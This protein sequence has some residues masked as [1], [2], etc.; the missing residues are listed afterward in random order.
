[1]IS[2]NLPTKNTFQISLVAFAISALVVNVVALFSTNSSLL[3]YV[4]EAFAFVYILLTPGLFLLPFLTHR[5]FHF[6]L[7]VTLS[8]ALSVLLL[9]VVGLVVNTLLPLF[10]DM[11]PLLPL[12]LLIAF[13]ILIFT[14]FILND[15]YKADFA[16][17]IPELNK[18]STALVVISFLLPIIACL[19]AISLNNGGSNFLS[20]LCLAIIFFLVPTLVIAEEWIDD[21]VP[22]MT[23]YF[24]ALTLLLMNSM[25]GWFV[26]G[27][28]IL[29][30]YHV[31]TLAND[32]HLW[33]IAIFR[34]P[35][36]ACLSL[37][38]LPSYLQNMLHVS[39]AYVF[40]LLF[41]FLGALPVVLVYYLSKRYTSTTISFLVGFLYISFPSFMVDMAFLNRQGIGFLFFGSM[42]FALL[43]TDHFSGKVR[44]LALFLFGTG[45]I[46]SHYSTA[47]V[48][49]ALLV[50]TYFLNKI[51]RFAMTMT[52]PR[53]FARLTDSFANKEVYTRPTLL[54]WPLVVGLVAIFFLWSV[55]ITK[56]STSFFIT[57]QQI[58]YNIEHPLALD[59]YSGPA[60][61]SLVQS[62]HTTPDELFNEFVQQT[63]AT[64]QETQ[65][66]SNLYP[67]SVSEQ[68]PAFPVFPV[69]EP[70][71]P[72]TVLGE[73]IQNVLHL[74]LADF[75]YEIKQVYAKVMQV[76]LII[77]FVGLGL[78][79]SFKKKIMKEIPAEFV[80]LSI[81]GIG[82]MVGQTLL[83]S[84][85]IDYGLLRLFQ[86]N[87]IFLGLPITLGFLALV[88]LVIKN[89]R[90]QLLVH[91]AFL[92][93]CFLIL[94]GFAPELTGGGRP[95]LPLNNYG[96]YYDAYYTH[97]QEISSM[98]WLSHQ[99]QSYPI[100][101][102]HYFS[103]VKMLAYVNIAPITGLLS[104]TIEKDSY[105]YLNYNNVKSSN[106]VEFINSDVFY[107]HF[108]TDFL[109][110]E[111][112]LIYSNGGSEVYK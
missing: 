88:S 65:A 12:P 47:Y 51:L 89:L 97:A 69:N 72:I 24:M 112:D 66:P 110:N 23:L 7:G 25:R 68:Y 101:S 58:A 104:Q 28:D 14:L 60:M 1:M 106:V 64:T 30:E 37:T 43:T 73:K 38:I 91:C 45:V 48:T 95:A 86:Q 54:T 90:A 42:L 2:H 70:L 8:V 50:A 32:A 87:L 53:W 39:D 111:K 4:G 109:Q 18:T 34:D 29:L 3:C 46:L 61:Y 9:M 83:P 107:Y 78:G 41:Q 82:I 31:F 63:V 20:M 74:S 67:L 33:N 5:K 93:A 27:H 99:D 81:A 59:D 102:D 21:S 19:G 16:L 17:E 10:G 40:K 98:D 100:Q 56:T 80:A 11:T 6:A 55:V 26:T 49:L 94:S 85:A 96:F 22:P 108:S 79:F 15:M 36:N 71:V 92:L 52:R 75:Y 77:G 84:S 57:L 103:S 76:L 35:Y 62:K 13:D 44:T 105:V